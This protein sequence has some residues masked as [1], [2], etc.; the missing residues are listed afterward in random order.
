MS[1]EDRW[2]L[3]LPIFN[4][5]F[6]QEVLET[7]VTNTNKYATSKNAGIPGAGQE[8][9]RPWKEVTVPELKIWLGLI[10]YMSVVR[11]T[12]VDEHWT[13]N[14]EWPK[15]CLMKFMGFNR[16]ANI[17]R[18]FHISPPVEGPLP[19]TRFFENLEPIASIVRNNF[20]RTAI[21]ATSVSIDEIIVQCTGRSKHTIMMRGKPCPVGYNVLAVCEAS[22]C[23]GFLFSSPIT[24]SD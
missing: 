5:F 12:R 21:P 11:L 2:D 20:Q 23:Y 22:Y 15:H 1:V 7:M 16:F 3:S 24:D 9:R 6:T 8:S 14:G 18:F 17:K 19:M 4:L 13:K 10:I